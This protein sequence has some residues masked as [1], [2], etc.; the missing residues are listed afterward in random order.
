[1]M[2]DL[3]EAGPVLPSLTNNRYLAHAIR[4]FVASI[5]LDKLLRDDKFRE[6]YTKIEVDPLL[7]LGST[8]TTLSS[9]TNSTFFCPKDDRS[10][11]SKDRTECAREAAE[12]AH[13]LFD[14][15][16]RANEAVG[17]SGHESGVGPILA[18][19]VTES[20]FPALIELLRQP[21]L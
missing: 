5:P 7:V 9:Q 1:M 6:L 20:K 3:V 2:A 14:L 12:L 15:I 21:K 16:D 8:R 18:R 11:D 19:A 4:E 13:H 17:E 10:D